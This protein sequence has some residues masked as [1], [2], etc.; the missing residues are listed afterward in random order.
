[1][2]Q[3]SWRILIYLQRIPYMCENYLL[4]YVKE[5]IHLLAQQISLH[6]YL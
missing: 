2:E 1:M 6:F 3:T 5:L 4:H